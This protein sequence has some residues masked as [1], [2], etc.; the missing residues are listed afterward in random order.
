MPN[1]AKYNDC[2][3]C[4]ACANACPVGCLSME[5]DITGF[6]YPIVDEEKCISCGA[7]E[8]ACPALKVNRGIRPDHSS[9][10]V[11]VQNKDEKVLMQSTSG[12]A[13]TAFAKVVLL[14]GGVVFGAK[15]DDDFNVRHVA[16]ESVDD[17]KYF[18]SSKYV[19]SQI[20][21]TY[22][23]ARQHLNGNRLVLFSGT[24]CQIAGLISFL[25]RD[26]DNLI[27]VDVMCRAVPSP[28][29]FKKYIDFV[30]SR[31]STIDKLIFRDKTLG[32]S[33][34]TMAIY[35]KQNGK[36]QV[37]RRGREADE[38]LRLFFGGYCTRES[39]NE[40][41]YQ[42]GKRKSD[43]TLWDCFRVYQIA[44]EM[45]N[46]KGATNVIAWTNKGKE[47]LEKA[48]VDL[49]VHELEFN[50]NMSNLYRIKGPKQIDEKNIFY[51]DVEILNCEDFFKKYTPNSAM[52]KVE[53]TFRKI[54]LKFGLHDTV[55]KIVHQYRDS[56]KSR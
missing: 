34:S 41:K 5:A 40:C 14:E 48:S 24:P 29:V 1:L 12:G 31:F 21:D 16:V 22:T 7:C 49:I 23:L 35:G 39:C 6:L 13:F 9:K 55:R 46:N 19:Q 42:T 36:K 43:I 20:G 50:P 27:T 8:R 28:K 51:Q 33:F 38:W 17:L 3:G 53:D 26:Y 10:H 4:N 56:R 32:Y 54:S 11:V 52:I 15:M 25:G 2:C 18:R 30:K 37:Y 45:D 44:P 47:I